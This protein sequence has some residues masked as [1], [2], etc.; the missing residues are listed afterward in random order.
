MMTTDTVMKECAVETTIAKNVKIGG[1]QG[2]GC[3]SSNGYDACFI[4]N[5]CANKRR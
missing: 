1:L 4:T 5:D 3:P 2:S